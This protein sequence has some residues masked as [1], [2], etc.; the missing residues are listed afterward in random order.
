M[1]YQNKIR[2]GAYIDFE[3]VKGDMFQ[4][5]ERGI[6]TMPI[7][8]NWGEDQKLTEITREDILGGNFKKMFGD[9]DTLVVELA[10][11]GCKKIL[12]YSINKGNK[13]TVTIGSTL[14][15]TA[16]HGGTFGNKISIGITSSDEV[17]TEVDGEVVDKQ[18]IGDYDELID[19]DWVTFSGSG[20]PSE[21]AF[22]QLS[23]GSNGSSSNNYDDYLKQIK[24]KEWN[25]LAVTDT[26]LNDK[27]EQLIKTLRDDE[28]IKVQG[29]VFDDDPNYE[30]I[31]KLKN[32]SVMLNDV[33]VTPIQLTAFVAGITAGVNVDKS[34]TNRLTPF[35]SIVDEMTNSEIETAIKG[36][37][38]V[39]SYRA[40]R[41]VKCEY[42]I[43]SF[44]DFSPS[45]NKDFSKNKII[46]VLDEVANTIKS[47][48]ELSYE[49]KVPNDAKGRDAFKSDLIK[50]FTKL[51]DARAIENF[52]AK[53]ITIIRGDSKE[54]VYVETYIQ[55]VD[56]MEKLYMLVRVR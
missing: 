26:N 42:D 20:S 18:S 2:P 7:T 44:T 46:R 13:A 55:P 12:L 40:D 36:G 8:V 27:A 29:V 52:S 22:T 51:Q 25:V 31:I 54:S 38:F 19:N 16:K 21:S 50:Y 5:G 48:F 28:K 14:T 24:T 41:T 37:F 33:K 32:Q 30:G 1:I 17:V 23:G 49:G 4:I 53:D 35:T 34:N 10:L 9:T 45:K 6:V 39:F 11:F 3:T 43:N 56:A 47:T 15:V